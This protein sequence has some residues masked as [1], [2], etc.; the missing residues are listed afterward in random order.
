MRRLRFEESLVLGWRCSLR[1]IFILKGFIRS[2]QGLNGERY[3]ESVRQFIRLVFAMQLASGKL[4]AF[5]GSGQ[6]FISDE[7]LTSP[8]FFIYMWDHVRRMLQ[9]Y[10]N[11]I[12][13]SRK[14]QWVLHF[15][16]FWHLSSCLHQ[17]DLRRHAYRH[18]ARGR[19]GAF[20]S[21][22]FTL[23][24]HHNME[25]WPHQTF[26][27]HLGGFGADMAGQG[28]SVQAKLQILGIV[29]DMWKR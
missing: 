13:Q 11:G 10:I 27:H 24:F 6:L 4:Q 9:G 5:G 1:R 14:I 23:L 7:N 28:C 19:L 21:V 26:F 22:T 12:L 29:R 20:H 16:S 3:Q 2:Q 18:F 8:Q 25:Q 15:H 17:F